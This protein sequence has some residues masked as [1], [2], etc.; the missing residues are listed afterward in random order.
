MPPGSVHLLVGSMGGAK[1][2][3]GGEDGGRRRKCSDPISR[4]NFR[5][6]NASRVL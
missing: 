6:I 5:K 2:T 1:G 3:G 4:T